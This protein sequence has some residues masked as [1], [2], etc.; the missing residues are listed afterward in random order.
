MGEHLSGRCYVYEHRRDFPLHVAIRALEKYLQIP[1]VSVT[2]EIEIPF[3]DDDNGNPVKIPAT[4][5]TFR[6]KRFQGHGK[7]GRPI[8]VCVGKKLLELTT[9]LKPGDL[10]RLPAGLCGLDG[11]DANGK[12]VGKRIMVDVEHLDGEPYAG[13]GESTGS[14]S[15]VETALMAVIKRLEAQTREI[16]E[17]LV[18][19]VDTL[20]R[21]VESSNKAQ[22][23]VAKQ[24]APVVEAAAQ[25]VE[26]ARNGGLGTTAEELRKIWD[27][28]PETSSNL[29][30]VLS[31]PVVVGAMAT[32]QKHVAEAAK[33]SAEAV[34][35]GGQPSQNTAARIARQLMKLDAEE[36]R[37]KNAE[38][39][40]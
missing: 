12:R 4:V 3:I 11:Y 10:G 31:S 34:A 39:K 22:I 24:A 23:E 1:Y 21:T 15:P 7:P 38:A 17:T 5:K 29:E 2:A 18:K 16:H 37:R 30:T 27:V 19:V 36:L 20:A 9:P 40:R 35:G 28:M 26:T 33:N 13:E 6:V 8:N 14:L 32:I 25:L